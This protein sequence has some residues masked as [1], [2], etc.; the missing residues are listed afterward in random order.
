MN[1]FIYDIPMTKVYFDENQLANNLGVEL[2]KLGKHVLLCFDNNNAKKTGIYNQIV[3]KVKKSGLE[4][5]ELSGIESNHQLDFVREG[6]EIC[7]E[8][9]IDAILVVGDGSI[10]DSVKFISA[11][12]FYK[13]DDH[14]LSTRKPF[15]RKRIPIISILTLAKTNSE[16]NDVDVASNMET[17]K[18]LLD[19]GNDFTI[20]PNQTACGSVDILTRLFEIYFI[21]NEM[22]KPLNMLEDLIKTVIKYAPLAI[23]KSDNYEA[24]AN[25]MWVSSWMINSYLNPQLNGVDQTYHS[26][27]H[28]LS[29]FYE[30]THGLGLSFLT[31]LWMKYVLSEKTVDR[32]YRYGINIWSLDS[33]KDK[34][35]VAKEAIVK[36][37][38]FFFEMFKLDKEKDW[39]IK[40][41][42]RILKRTF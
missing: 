36:T 3:G 34:M 22:E 35:S 2:Q 28:E 26:L 30:I 31:P 42:M 19:P 17:K 41:Y 39:D 32:F 14:H 15:I 16:M 20:N 21:D 25:L 7:K 8:K 24:R 10:I 12:T 9:Q 18:L 27:E 5:F 1:A 23:E 4:L 6:V 13:E 33:R 37:A 38:E 40:S 11:A 29:A